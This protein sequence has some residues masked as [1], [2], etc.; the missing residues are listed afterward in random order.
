VASAEWN[1]L[2][3]LTTLKHAQVLTIA[4]GPMLEATSRAYAEY[5]AA[6]KVIRDHGGGLTYESM[7]QG[8]GLMRRPLPEVAIRADGWR[9]W[10]AGLTHFGLSPA[11]RGKVKRTDGEGEGKNPAASYFGA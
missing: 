6:D 2:V 1:R 11:T 5:E 9:R 10:T 4:D 7:T 8:G 3:E